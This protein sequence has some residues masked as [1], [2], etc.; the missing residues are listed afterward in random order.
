MSRYACPVTCP[1]NP[2]RFEAYDEIIAVHDRLDSKVFPRL[3]QD[4]NRRGL[5]EDPPFDSD[6][7]LHDY[8]IGQLFRAC[9]DAG[10]TF[11]QRWQSRKL[12]GLTNDE[13]VLFEAQSRIHV[14]A[15]E[16]RTARNETLCEATDLLNPQEPIFLL[17]DHSMAQTA[18]RFAPYLAW[19]YDLPHYRRA[20]GV[21]IAIPE[22]QGLEPSEVVRTVARHLGW[23]EQRESL[24]NWLDLHFALC[25]EALAAIPP[26]LWEKTL[27]LSNMT[28]AV[29]RYR[30]LVG[31]EDFIKA[32]TKRRDVVTG[33]MEDGLAERGFRQS[34]DWLDETDH[35]LLTM[36]D[37]GARPLRATISLGETEV[38]LT[39]P[40]GRAP[41]AERAEFERRLGSR[42]AFELERA[43]DLGRQATKSSV[44]PRQ[45]ELVPPAFLP[46]A[47][48]YD[49]TF[50]RMPAGSDQSATK[51][52]WLSSI[53][54]RWIDEPV[55]ALDN[56]TPRQAATDTAR[57][58]TLV[59]LV[60]SRIRD[61][62][63]RL[64][65]EFSKEDSESAYEDDPAELAR[66]LGLS[67]LDVPAPPGLYPPPRPQL[68]PLPA[69]ALSAEEVAHRAEL[70][71]AGGSSS[72]D[73]VLAR[74]DVEADEACQALDFLQEDN[75]W[76]ALLELLVAMAWFILFPQKRPANVPPGEELAELANSTLDEWNLES[77]NPTAEELKEYLEGQRQPALVA[78]L[79][80][81][82]FSAATS[83][84]G[85]KRIE[86]TTAV[87]MAIALRV[88]VDALDETAR[89][90]A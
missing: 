83:K 38:L 70:L 29:C 75:G 6:L 44:T 25:A 16:I 28:R 60:K 71:I 78:M 24:Q 51:E 53:S 7:A 61:A 50:S 15:I 86:F 58:P 27:E 73:S 66:E 22:V 4:L 2:W 12:E 87:E 85:K 63:Q 46:Q 81:Q 1:F 18:G 31:P 8:F 21:A 59:A 17:A 48:R 84:L 68:P 33:E 56:L 5:K 54:R 41:D 47:R 10:Q 64:I 62:D 77:E 14:R 76:P 32:L 36:A 52:E 20:H 90:R 37:A 13:R 45:R 49:I 30:L 80:D 9:D 67:E 23:T 19:L 82:L 42:V 26:V 79:Q 69:S 43:D 35:Q 89:P 57:R 34:W 65:Q 72:P 88:L 40:A 3:R 74:F 11:F 55:P 39:I